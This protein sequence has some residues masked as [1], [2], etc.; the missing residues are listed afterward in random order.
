[1]NTRRL[2]SALLLASALTFAA[3]SAQDQSDLASLRAKAEKGN[4]IAQ[5]NLGLAYTRGGD[6]PVDPVEAYVWLSLAQENGARGRALETLAATLDEPTLLKAR[7]TLAQRRA[8]LHGTAVPEVT[9]PANDPVARIRAER[10]ALS[11]KLTELAAELASLRAERNRLAQLVADHEKS[12]VTVAAE[13]ATA[14][15]FA[16]QV[17]S[18]LNKLNDEKAAL[19]SRL[20]SAET[21]S[22][23]TNA[24]A[25]PDAKLRDLETRLAAAT[26]QAEEAVQNAAAISR[27]ST[28]DLNAATA[29]IDE[30]KATLART[31][32]PDAAQAR[33]TARIAE[34]EDQLVA[35]SRA[36]PPAYPDLSSRV[37]ELET[38]LADARAQVTALQPAPTAPAAE[39]DAAPVD[40]PALQKKLAETEDRLST[41]LRGY[42]LLQR[43]TDEKAAAARQ[44]TDALA[45]ERAELGSRVADLEVEAAAAKA[46]VTRL[47]AELATARRAAEQ[48]T[49]ELDAERAVSRQLRGANTTL[50][51]ENYALKTRLAPTPAG[52]PVTPTPVTPAA[53]A[54]E[55][56]PSA[57][58]AEART[59]TVVAGDSLS[60]LAQRYYGDAKRWPEIYQAN[61][62]KFGTDTTLRVGLEL[63]IP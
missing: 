34:L 48:A 10:D 24:P 59:H 37:S 49:S 20:R 33:L 2:R 38:Q 60:K 50:A 42:A 11:T 52:T 31:Q 9:A 54:T 43:Q 18:T 23:V 21:G 1:M 40:V 17:E 44:S 30:L 63:R 5:Y 7:Q 57:A 25:E 26:R 46:D 27:Q 32:S 47:S 56:N 45:N 61:R 14:R 53:I 39:G 15:N 22:R 58:V 36:R 6:V 19:E 51:N 29:Q 28:T 35:A 12:S 3:A 62:E 13:L 41:A 4:G 55:T 8:Q 16:Q